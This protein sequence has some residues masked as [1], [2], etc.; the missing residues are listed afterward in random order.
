MD[1]LIDNLAL[2]MVLALAVLLFSGYPVAL[3][4][5]GVALSFGLIGHAL[6]EFPFIALFNIPLRI[7]STLAEN[8]IYPAVPMLLFMGI[9]LEKAASDASCCCA[10]RCCCA[11]CR[12]VRRSP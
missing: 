6:G 9:A 8:L 10:R 5:I 7:Y 2:F 1:F 12:R 4:L 3:V 11:A